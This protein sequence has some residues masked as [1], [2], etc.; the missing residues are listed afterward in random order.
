MTN[1]FMWWISEY[2]TVSSCARFWL[3]ETIQKLVECF[4]KD[5]PKPELML[6]GLYLVSFSNT[7]HVLWL[8]GLKAQGYDR[9]KVTNWRWFLAYYI[10][11]LK[12]ITLI[13]VMVSVIYDIPTCI[14][15]NSGL[16]CLYNWI[17]LWR[18]RQ[19]HLSWVLTHTQPIQTLLNNI[20]ILWQF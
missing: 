12:F 7:N 17:N 16:P 5:L 10:S 13:R 14:E 2:M 20:H 19:S 4:N 6:P 11:C 15:T 1:L 9:S 8:K 18:E 3:E